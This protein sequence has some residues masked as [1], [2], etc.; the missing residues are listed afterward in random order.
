MTCVH[1]KSSSPKENEGY[2]GKSQKI[3]FGGGKNGEIFPKKLAVR[4]R[5]PVGDNFSLNGLPSISK[6]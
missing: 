2:E 6:D 4:S 5:L 3:I 1:A